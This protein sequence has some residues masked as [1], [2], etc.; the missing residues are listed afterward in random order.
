MTL[1][2]YKGYLGSVEFDQDERLFYGK[3]AYIRALVSY[4]ATDAEGLVRAFREAVDDYLDQCRAQGVA[5]ESPLKGSFNVR[6]GPD[7]HRRA[8]IAAKRAGLSLNAFVTRALES[9]VDRASEPSA[10][11]LEEV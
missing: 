11:R 8:V 10:S 9:A 1:L 7:L 5:P 3:L 4:E 2:T 6:I